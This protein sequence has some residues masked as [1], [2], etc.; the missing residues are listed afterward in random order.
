M[1]NYEHIK[2][3]ESTRVLMEEKV[4]AMESALESLLAIDEDYQALIAYYYSEQR[5][6]DLE[7]DHHGKIP[8]SLARGVLSEDEIYNLMLSYHELAISM[9]KAASKMLE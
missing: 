8:E 6:Q 4:H 2:T 7:D 9:L 1:N 3:Y 5:E